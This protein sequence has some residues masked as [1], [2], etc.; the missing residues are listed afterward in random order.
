MEPSSSKAESMSKQ[1]VRVKLGPCSKSDQGLALMLYTGN[2]CLEE[3]DLE[4]EA[5]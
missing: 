1:L 2:I 5:E 3:E 4:F